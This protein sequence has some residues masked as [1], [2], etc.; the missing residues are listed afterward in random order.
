MTESAALAPASAASAASAASSPA[1]HVPVELDPRRIAMLEAMGL[2]GLSDVF[3]TARP[4]PADTAKAPT[5]SILPT[6]GAVNPPATQFEPQNRPLPSANRA[7]IAIEKIAIPARTSTTADPQRIQAIARMDWDQLQ[8]EVKNCQACGLCQSRKNTVFGVG[9]PKTEDKA[10][11]M[12]VGEAPGENEDLQGEPF[13]GQAGKLLDN[14]LKAAGQTRNPDATD[15]QPAFI[16]NA[17]KCRPPANRNPS[18]EEMTQCAPLLQRQIE[19]V[20]PSLIL[21]LGK[22]AIQ[23]LLGSNEPIGK[24]RGQVHHYS[25]QNG[26]KTPVIVSYH[27]AYLLRSLGEKAKAWEDLKLA[28]AQSRRSP[29]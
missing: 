15:L 27:P 10:G 21:A 13:V 6:S 26:R 23:A 17:L 20:Q 1:A 19:L 18:A 25:A 2:R 29:D 4:S 3:T 5:A 28:I 8:T 24:L 22:F 16:A 12:I 11:W 14:M 7:S 9:R